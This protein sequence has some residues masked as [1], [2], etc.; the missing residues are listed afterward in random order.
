VRFDRAYAAAPITLPSHAT[1][2]TGRY[3][4][5]HGSRHNLIAV[6]SKVPTLPAIL[7]NR[8]FATA[9]FIAAFPLDHRFGLSR[10]FDVYGDRLP[11]DL[12]G[13][14]LNE[15]PGREVVDEAIVW[16]K[17]ETATAAPRRFF[18]WVHLFEPHA[19]YGDPRKTPGR[20]AIDR[21]DDEIAI[22]DE[23]V[24]RLLQVVRSAAPDTAVVF[25]SDHGE[26]LGEHGELTHSLFI[27]DT[28]LRV[29]LVM[30][31]PAI[32]RGIVV[33]GRVG[34]VDVMA[35]AMKTLGL[36]TVD[37]DGIDLTPAFGGARLPSRELYAESF[38]PLFDFGW[39][40]L[41]SVRSSQWKLIAAPR[42]ELFDV[43]RDP[44]ESRDLAAA[45][46]REASALESRVDRYSSADLPAGQQGIDLEAAGRLRALGYVSGGGTNVAA[47]SRPD[48]KDRRELAA[49]F[50]QI[51]SGELSNV[52]LRHA[53]EAILRE[54][55]KNPQANLR[56][57]WAL[58]DAGRTREAEP[59]FAAAVAGHA[60]SADPYLGLAAC[61][62]ARG[63][64][65]AAL[66]TLGEVGP[67]DR[68]NPVV[69][70]NVGV[71]EMQ[72]GHLEAA[73]AALAHAV[74]DDP[75]FSEAR[76]NLARAYARAGR[77]DAAEREG[78]ELLSRLTA[79]APQRPEA[80]RLVAAVR[81]AR[82][83]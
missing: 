21:Y 73:V 31:G 6:D 36:A 47:A 5:G 67:T 41:R 77:F 15:R 79:D 70:A 10:G 81:A 51:A 80:L 26:G 53:L 68:Q 9:A 12:T 19:P 4:P 23:Q 61:Q 42:P 22:A 28:T 32:P 48:P 64:L 69:L 56:L 16:L 33:S 74:A 24:G 29:P 65:A 14:P 63:D 46:A 58:L 72:L 71:V 37:T 59:H 83:R 60:P 3:P 57:G 62:T 17:R 8:G 38:A 20:S 49:R 25:A 27:Y 75:E 55:P 66:R 45:N 2:L 30:A 40:P 54:D 82:G 7:R 52:A 13:R 78:V 11:R 34:L 76:F 18:L 43:D 1:I 35:T 39:S 44:A 50:A